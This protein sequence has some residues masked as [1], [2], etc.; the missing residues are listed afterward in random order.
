MVIIH[1]L[2]ILW[3]VS[4]SLPSKYVQIHMLK[5]NTQVAYEMSTD[6]IF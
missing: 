2:N 6:P 5:V 3:P 4:G 1:S